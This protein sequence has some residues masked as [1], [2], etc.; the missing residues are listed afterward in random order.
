[1]LS[2]S[3]GAGDEVYRWVDKAGVVHYGAQPPSKDAKPAT[4]PQLQTYSS[5]ASTKALPVSPLDAATKPLAAVGIKEMR[6]LSPVQDEIFRDPTGSV[7]VSV[8]VLPGLPEGAGVLFYLDGAAKNSKPSASTSM[9][10]GG[11]ER[12]EHSV[13]AA[14]VD[15]SGKE[16]MRAPAV[17][18]HNK[19]P[20]AR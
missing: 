1:M 4:L 6:I 13:T 5:R 8:A 15:M 20:L 7:N 10:I 17:T 12:G 9:T 3:A 19:P 11:V 14:V 18:F 16:L 2:L